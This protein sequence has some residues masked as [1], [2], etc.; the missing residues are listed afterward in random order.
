MPGGKQGHSS[1]EVSAESLVERV[2]VHHRRPLQVESS[3]KKQY[4]Q[5]LSSTASEMTLFGNKVIADI[6]D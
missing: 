1:S 2:D 6:V 4:V 3:T 5:V